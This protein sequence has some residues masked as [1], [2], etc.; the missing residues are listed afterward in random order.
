MSP[1]AALWGFLAFYVT[2]AALT[3][4]AY[5][6]KGGLLHDSAHGLGLSGPLLSP[7]L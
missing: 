4:F 3:W 1:M 7:P 5:T 6:R 2:C